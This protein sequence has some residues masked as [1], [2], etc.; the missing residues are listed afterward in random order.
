MLLLL[1]LLPP[2]P[3]LL[4]A[5]SL[6]HAPRGVMRWIFLLRISSNI[7]VENDPFEGA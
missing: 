5:G 1:L 7:I 6:P 2:P 4:A 3:P